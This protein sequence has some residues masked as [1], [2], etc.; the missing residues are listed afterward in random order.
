MSLYSENEEYDLIKILQ[1]S[2]D[3]LLEFIDNL[4]ENNRIYYLAYLSN[5][6]LDILKL[7]IKEMDI[8][9]VPKIYMSFV[10]KILPY[11]DEENNYLIYKSYISRDIEYWELLITNPQYVNKL[12][13]LLLN[14]KRIIYQ[15]YDQTGGFDIK[16]FVGNILSSGTTAGK[17]LSAKVMQSLDTMNNNFKSILKIHDTTTSAEST[18]KNSL[19]DLVRKFLKGVT[20]KK[21]VGH[22]DK[23]GGNGTS[24]SS[25]DPVVATNF[26][27]EPVTDVSTDSGFNDNR[28]TIEGKVMKDTILQDVINRS[29]L[30]SFHLLSEQF[31]KQRKASDPVDQNTKLSLIEKLNI[32]LSSMVMPVS[33]MKK[34]LNDD[35]QHSIIDKL[36]YHLFMVKEK[37][38]VLFDNLHKTLVTGQSLLARLDKPYD[39]TLETPERFQ[40]KTLLDIVHAMLNKKPLTEEERDKIKRKPENEKTPVDVIKLLLTDIKTLTQNAVNH[41]EQRPALEGVLY[42]V[43]RSSI[44]SKMLGANVE[45]TIS[46][47]LIDKIKNEAFCEQAYEK[48][49]KIKKILDDKVYK[50]NNQL[51]AVLERH[52]ISD[53]PNK[54]EIM[55]LLRSSNK[56]KPTVE[57]SILSITNTINKIFD[58]FVCKKGIKLET[59]EDIRKGEEIRSRSEISDKIIDLIIN[60]L[61]NKLSVEYMLQHK[62]DKTLKLLQIIEKLNIT[63]VEDFNNSNF[64]N[65]EEQ[66]NKI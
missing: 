52:N 19:I 32:M 59:T 25:T 27:A 28:E 4:L 9:K 6:I 62:D 16:Q 41:P 17:G 47:E 12:K 13:L 64:K 50:A 40:E 15:A 35:T 7:K 53:N 20:D 5:D 66:Y 14:S 43:L 30:D 65:I 63:R 49:E 3:E 37:D 23:V 58:S 21:T 11:V 51:T 46:D 22:K 8:S 29:L 42:K 45:K 18:E 60:L 61:Q 1:Y 34:K 39:T 31:I 55:E 54:T 56:N 26:V 57:N 36:M 10:N 44:N 2:D 33:E 48:I 24:I 38:N